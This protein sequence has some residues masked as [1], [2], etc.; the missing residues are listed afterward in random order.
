MASPIAIENGSPMVGFGKRDD[1]VE[2]E[3]GIAGRSSL[4][5][6]EAHGSAIAERGGVKHSVAGGGRY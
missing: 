1:G 2:I 6:T 5:D 3:G 4:S